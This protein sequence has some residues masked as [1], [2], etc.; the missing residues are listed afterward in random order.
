M[1]ARARGGGFG[2]PGYEGSFPRAT[3]SSRGR[4]EGFR[5]PSNLAEGMDCFE[6]LATV[7]GQLLQDENKDKGQTITQKAGCHFA[8]Y[9]TVYERAGVASDQNH[10]LS[11]NKIKDMLCALHR[12]EEVDTDKDFKNEEDKG[13]FMMC[14]VP[15][16][17]S[18]VFESQ[19][20]ELCQE[21]ADEAKVRCQEN[22][23]QELCTAIQ[24]EGVNACGKLKGDTG[25]VTSMKFM[26]DLNRYFQ[27]EIVAAGVSEEFS[28][29]DAH[30]EAVEG[31]ASSQMNVD[32][33]KAFLKQ[34]S[35]NQAVEHHDMFQLKWPITAVDAE[36][37]SE[38]LEVSSSDLD[39]VDGGGKGKKESHVSYKGC[40]KRE[41]QNEL[42]LCDETP[43][44]LSSG[45]S[46]E[47]AMC[48]ESKPYKM[49][50]DFSLERKNAKNHK[51]HNDDDDN[52]SESVVPEMEL[53]KPSRLSFMKASAIRRLP[54]CTNRNRAA[55]AGSKRKRVNTEVAGPS[56]KIGS[57]KSGEPH[58]KLSIKSFTVPELSVNV[59]ESSTVANLKRAVM[60]AAMNLLGGGLCVRVLLQGKKVP[61]ENASLGQVGISRSGKLD[62]L[63]FML[64]PN[65]MSSTSTSEDPVLVL[66]HVASQPTSRYPIFS[67]TGEVGQNAMKN[68]T[69]SANRMVEA[70]KGKTT[71]AR[72]QADRVNHFETDLMPSTNTSHGQLVQGSGTL[73]LHPGLVG[74]GVK[75]LVVSMRQKSQGMV[76]G[77]RRI[78]RPFAVA[79]VEALVHAVE[80]LGTGRWR[81]VKLCAFEQAKHRTYVDLKVHSI[82]TGCIS[83]SDL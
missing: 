63:G 37:A 70:N 40:I 1:K 69:D 16:V 34:Y 22:I 82:K 46:G 14:H 53:K 72:M 49:H 10:S 44:L 75:G 4:G 80:K 60:D 78:R 32:K 26:S 77:K 42:L 13:R 47:T 45:S 57:R 15:G 27:K 31:S 35:E 68:C 11:E 58:V 65:P 74:D 29:P 6:L 25:R 43:P 83:V 18:S 28:L 12:G 50:F 51:I 19:T 38:K 79:E 9:K 73:I 2:Y 23:V 36:V 59:P 62:S 41:A 8:K 76:V 52:T 67:M 48:I 39:G 24:N 33:L 3:R 81:D 30:V 54:N 7:A 17:N 5:K 66:S 64:E 56:S 21:G 55:G 20:T 61:D 71:V